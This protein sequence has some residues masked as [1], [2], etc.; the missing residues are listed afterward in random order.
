MD[1]EVNEK[2][3]F[4]RFEKH[5]EFIAA[6]Q[7]LLALDLREKPSFD[8]ENKEVQLLN[9]LIIIVRCLIFRQD[10]GLIT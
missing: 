3:L 6:Q 1:E 9:K 2:K 7:A 10:A 4:A 5:G 8:E